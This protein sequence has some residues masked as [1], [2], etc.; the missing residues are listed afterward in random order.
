M[1]RKKLESISLLSHLTMPEIIP[2]MD[3]EMLETC[4]TFPGI[5]E[6]IDHSSGDPR[7]KEEIISFYSSLNK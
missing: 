4:L 3:H 6:Q 7:A 2:K 1:A 5:I